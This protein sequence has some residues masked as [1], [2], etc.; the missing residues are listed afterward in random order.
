M[1]SPAQIPI[2][3]SPNQ[4]NSTHSKVMVLISYR[5]PQATGL[6]KL[7]DGKKRF[8]AV[9]S[10]RHAWKFATGFKAL[11]RACWH[12]SRGAIDK[13]SACGDVRAGT[14]QRRL[15]RRHDDGFASIGA[16]GSRYQG[17][18]KAKITSLDW[19]TAP[20]YPIKQDYRT[21]PGQIV[22]C[23]MAVRFSAFLLLPRTVKVPILEKLIIS[24]RGRL[25]WRRESGNCC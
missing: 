16:C 7:H 4:T 23:L 2:L 24:R 20:R 6:G 19:S 14:E 18:C 1:P 3:G 13:M 21:I 11:G 17:L 22:A 25:E 8:E 9:P 12:T 15:F 10:H 5:F